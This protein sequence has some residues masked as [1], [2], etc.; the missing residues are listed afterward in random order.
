[1]NEIQNQN[2][3]FEDIKHID[4]NGVAHGGQDDIHHVV[5]EVIGF[6]EIALQKAV[7]CFAIGIRPQAHPTQITHD[8]RIVQTHFF[9]QLIV[10]HF[11]FLRIFEALAE[12][13]Q[14]RSCRIA[15]Y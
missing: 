6:T 11:V 15:R 10:P 4:E 2:S 12:G 3:T 13:F 1:M 5:L 14:F 8:K 7:E 9:A